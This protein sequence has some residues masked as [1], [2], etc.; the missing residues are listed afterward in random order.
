MEGS[1]NLCKM[2]KVT[3]DGSEIETQDCLIKESIQNYDHK[4]LRSRN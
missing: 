1:D 2:A 4:C 3:N